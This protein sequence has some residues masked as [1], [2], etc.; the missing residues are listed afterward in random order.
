MKSGTLVIRDDTRGAVL[1]MLEITND[2]K[3]WVLPKGE[4]AWFIAEPEPAIRTGKAEWF[5]IYDLW[6]ACSATATSA[7]KGRAPP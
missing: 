7:W 2:I 1:A 3:D 6:A 5:G 4:S